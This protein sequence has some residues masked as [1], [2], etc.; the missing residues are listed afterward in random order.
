ML[1]D[2]IIELLGRKPKLTPHQQQ[3]ARKAEAERRTDPRDSA[4]LQC[5]PQHDFPARLPLMREE[6][7][8]S[9]SP[10]TLRTLKTAIF[11]A[12]VAAMLFGAVRTASGSPL[13]VVTCL[14]P[15]GVNIASDIERD[16]P[17]SAVPEVYDPEAKAYV[18]HPRKTQS[19]TITVNGDGTATETSFN[20]DGTAFVTNMRVLG[21]INPDAVSMIDDNGRNVEFDLR[22]ALSER[23]NRDLHRHQLFRLA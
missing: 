2:K 12:G 9:C 21:T 10:R 7:G 1:I 4:Q 19:I 11:F 17:K 14:A 3:E 20:E 16:R 23:F 18:S 22:Y 6:G 15:T 5:Q 8:Q 13:M